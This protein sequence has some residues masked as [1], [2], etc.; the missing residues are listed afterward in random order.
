MVRTLDINKIKTYTEGIID[1]AVELISSVDSEL[2]P[3]VIDVYK[4]M[5]DECRNY[6]NEFNL[7]DYTAR[8]LVYATSALHLC[9]A[10]GVRGTESAKN[11]LTNNIN[12]LVQFTQNTWYQ[13]RDAGEAVR[14]SELTQQQQDLINEAAELIAM[15][16]VASTAGLIGEVIALTVITTISIAVIAAATFLSP[17][18]LIITAVVSP[19]VLLSPIVLLPVIYSVYDDICEHKKQNPNQNLTPQKLYDIVNERNHIDNGISLI[20]RKLT[21]V[22]TSLYLK[23]EKNMQ[24]VLKETIATKEMVKSVGQ[25]VSHAV[26]NS[27]VGKT[28]SKAKDVV[29]RSASKVKTKFT[30]KLKSTRDEVEQVTGSRSRK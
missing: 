1:D 25:N 5:A 16:V 2:V 12:D 7:K 23:I 15:G 6:Y 3:G 14:N 13:A 30:E 8:A 27:K 17:P 11:K 9:E 22:V 24:S 10:H 20:E 21:A 26:S 28:A 29:Q 4:F 19:Y 18:A